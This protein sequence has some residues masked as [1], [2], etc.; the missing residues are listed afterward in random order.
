[1]S[2]V[3]V[4]PLSQNLHQ[5][6]AHLDK[7]MSALATVYE[8]YRRNHLTARLN[9]SVTKEPRTR[10][11]HWTR[12]GYPLPTPG[13]DALREAVRNQNPSVVY[14]I[15][16]ADGDASSE[17][18][19]DA[20]S[21]ATDGLSVVLLFNNVCPPCD[22]AILRKRF[23][24]VQVFQHVAASLIFAAEMAALRPKPPVVSDTT[25]VWRGSLELS[26]KE[27]TIHLPSFELHCL[28]AKRPALVGREL[29]VGGCT[30]RLVAAAD[31]LSPFGTYLH[32]H[33]A[34]E[35]RLCSGANENTAKFVN[36]WVHSKLSMLIELHDWRL[37]CFW[38]R[39]IVNRLERLTCRALVIPQIPVKATMAMA[40]GCVPE[41]EV[42]PVSQFVNQLPVFDVDDLLWEEG[43][44]TDLVGG[45]GKE[46]VAIEK[47]CAQTVFGDFAADFLERSGRGNAQS[48]GVRGCGT[49]NESSLR[50][51]LNEFI[52]K[53]SEGP[54]G[55]TKY[56]KMDFG[57]SEGNAHYEVGSASKKERLYQ[58]SEGERSGGRDRD[59]ENLYTEKEFVRDAGND[60]VISS[61]GCE[62]DK[63]RAM[64]HRLEEKGTDVERTTNINPGDEH[65]AGPEEQVDSE[66][67]GTQV[68]AAVEE[69]NGRTCDA[70]A[71]PLWEESNLN[72]SMDQAVERKKTSRASRAALSGGF[73]A[74]IDFQ[75][76][77]KGMKRSRTPLIVETQPLPGLVCKMEGNGLSRSNKNSSA[78]A[79]RPEGKASTGVGVT[80]ANQIQSDIIVV[81]DSSPE[82][83][84]ASH[85]TSNAIRTEG[86]SGRTTAS[87]VESGF[88]SA[89]TCN[90]DSILTGRTRSQRSRTE[91]EDARACRDK[92]IRQR[93]ERLS[94]ERQG[95]AN[96][97]RS[98]RR[99]YPDRMEQQAKRARVNHGGSYRKT[100]SNNL[101]NIASAHVKIT[102]LLESAEPFFDHSYNCVQNGQS[103]CP[104][105]KQ[106]RCICD[107]QRQVLN[108]I[109]GGEYR[110]PQTA[111]HGVEFAQ[112]EDNRDE[113]LAHYE[114]LVGYS[115]REFA[116]MT[117]RLDSLVLLKL[118]KGVRKLVALG[119]RQHMRGMAHDHTTVDAKSHKLLEYLLRKRTATCSEQLIA[120]SKTTQTTNAIT[121]KL[122]EEMAP[123]MRRNEVE[124]GKAGA[125][126]RLMGAFNARGKE[127][128]SEDLDLI[129]MPT[130]M[131]GHSGRSRSNCDV[132]PL[133]FECAPIFGVNTTEDCALLESSR[134]MGDAQTKKHDTEVSRHEL[135]MQVLVAL[136]NDEIGEDDK[137]LLLQ[138]L[139][140]NG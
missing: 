42:R 54:R 110:Y 111:G 51:A 50:E 39:E 1:M 87:G 49:R 99:T 31:A 81:M 69:G 93:Y 137:R 94:R 58:Q 79:S 55:D 119:A 104:R 107:I 132:K 91:V 26:G 30:A 102:N 4:F 124:D 56:W 138:N 112:D 84:N 48:A 15:H 18:D 3:A 80:G 126:T 13:T 47:N 76:R 97:L 5:F 115:G 98:M 70:S 28:H 22:V 43:E 6:K 34:F 103:Q 121:R 37:W 116:S 88:K 44:G 77:F 117:K 57:A 118:D 86:P 35:M 14:V 113:Y 82:N 106:W 64:G 63:R 74:D 20:I 120:P 123:D 33:V 40:E 135:V 139:T 85:G 46:D 133:Q 16:P 66:G 61:D 78:L 52:A 59:D 41:G 7:S 96:M 17:S 32:A 108:K 25:M 122:Q 136:R 127:A 29:P 128:C 9:S 90:T 114:K 71:C 89:R 12:D 21:A 23:H 2:S 95:E 73:K 45:V 125:Y 105:N 75:P 19:L 101:A 11:Q 130:M 60:M 67:A 38:R 10:L 24:A 92:L 134:A 129:C 65:A 27:E 109:A 68:G 8:P 72:L 131:S 83:G 53:L 140:R 36:A 62:D 100:S